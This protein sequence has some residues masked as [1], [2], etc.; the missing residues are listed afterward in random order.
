MLNLQG[1]TAVVTGGASGIG[2]ACADLLERE[3]VRVARWDVQANEQQRKS[4]VI[5]C[6]VSDVASIA[7]AMK[8]TID[9]F[10]SPSLLV[11]AA[12]TGSYTPILE[13]DT[14]TWDR[15]FAVN[16]RGVMLSVQAVAR[17]IVA[18]K[19]DGALVL[20][21]SVNGV[22]ADPG[23]SAYSTSKAGVCHFARVAAREFGTNGI[24]VNAIAPGPTETPMIAPALALPGY[25]EEVIRRTP[26][27][28]IGTPQR[29]AE[30]VVGLMKMDWVTG[31][32]LMV[33]GGSSLNT[34]RGA[35]NIRQ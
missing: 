17:A 5:D 16:L 23:I 30:G 10:G 35:W 14:A 25:R 31:Q 28:E 29:I 34:G 22:V 4:G 13:M 6:D 18:A 1:R 9:R 20:I 15:I 26:L 11:A 27:G 12:G 33:D 32:V 19:G 7:A 3:G 8:L 21:A 2:A 24:R